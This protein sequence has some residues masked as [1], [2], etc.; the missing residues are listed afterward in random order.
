MELL[1]KVQITVSRK[2]RKK[3]YLSACKYGCTGRVGS[4]APE[5]Q[6]NENELCGFCLEQEKE[7]VALYKFEVSDDLLSNSF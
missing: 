5:V 4:H 7:K 2:H 3:Y 1:N 6:D